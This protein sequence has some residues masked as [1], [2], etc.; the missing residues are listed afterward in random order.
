MNAPDR[1]FYSIHANGTQGLIVDAEGFTV[2]ELRSHWVS[3]LPLLEQLCREH[4]RQ[5]R[6]QPTGR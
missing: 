1:W 2:L 5:Q 6:G 3:L 4:N